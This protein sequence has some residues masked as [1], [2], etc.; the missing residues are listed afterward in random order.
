[1]PLMIDGFTFLGVDAYIQ[2]I[3]KGVIIVAAMGANRLP[4]RTTITSRIGGG[5]GE[6]RPWSSLTEER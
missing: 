1:M 5:F 4:S 3:A 2:D 6:G